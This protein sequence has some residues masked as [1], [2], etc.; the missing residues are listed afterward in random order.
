MF[1]NIINVNKKRYKTFLVSVLYQVQEEELSFSPL[2]SFSQCCTCHCIFMFTIINNPCYCGYTWP[3][4]RL[5][6]YCGSPCTLDS[7]ATVNS[8]SR[9]YVAVVRDGGAR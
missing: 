7:P 9:R 5:S 1:N 3:S 8:I 6:C 4:T 2:V